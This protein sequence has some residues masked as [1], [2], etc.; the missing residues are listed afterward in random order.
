MNTLK[1][2]DLNTFKEVLM[3]PKMR[4][5]SFVPTW[6]IAKK[7]IMKIKEELAWQKLEDFHASGFW[8]GKS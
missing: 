1:E 3:V 6:T 2:K 8:L 4:S 5:I 7:E